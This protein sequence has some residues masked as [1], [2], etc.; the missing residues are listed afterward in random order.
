MLGHWCG[1]PFHYLI[2]NT[3]TLFALKSE[4]NFSSSSS[5]SL[6]LSVC[7]PLPPLCL[8]KSLMLNLSSPHPPLS[9][10]LSK[11]LML[12]ISPPPPVF[13]SLSLC[14]VVCFSVSVSLS[15]KELYVRRH[16][17][18]LPRRLC[19]PCSIVLVYVVVACLFYISNCLRFHVLRNAVERTNISFFFLL[20]FLM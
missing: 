7:L 10:S 16:P 6:C 12:N 4:H 8:S 19:R 15:L 9:L 5:S 18:R 2:R 13:L 11:R 20:L 1:T 17:S 14:L 3:T